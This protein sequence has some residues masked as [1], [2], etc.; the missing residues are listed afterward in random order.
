MMGEGGKHR[1]F[2]FEEIKK[3]KHLCIVNRKYVSSFLFK[4]GHPQGFE[5]LYNDNCC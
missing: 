3:E 4:F 1:L 2:S 5:L